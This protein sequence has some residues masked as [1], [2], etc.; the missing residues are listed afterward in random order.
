[1]SIAETLTALLGKTHGTRGAKGRKANDHKRAAFDEKE[2]AA[3]AQ[4]LKTVM[5]TD[6]LTLVGSVQMI[7]LGRLRSHFGGRWDTVSDKVHALVRSVIEKRTLGHDVHARLGEDT[8]VVV[9]SRMQPEAARMKGALM[10]EEIARKIFGDSPPADLIQVGVASLSPDDEPEEVP[11]PA[12][13]AQA[14]LRIAAGSQESVIDVPVPPAA[15]ASVAGG[16]P[17]LRPN[18]TNDASGAGTFNSADPNWSRSGTSDSKA[19][20]SWC[21]AGKDES[22]PANEWQRVGRE[23]PEFMHEWRRIGR[24][25][26]E[27]EH[28]WRP[29]ANGELGIPQ[30]LR[31]VYQPAWLVNRQVIAAHTF[32]PARVA[33]DGIVVAGGAAMPYRL[34]TAENYSLDLLGLMKVMRNLEQMAKTRAQACVIFPL[35]LQTLDL[36]RQRK[37][38]TDYATSIPDDMRAKLL[39]E[40]MGI[41]DTTPMSTTANAVSTLKPLCRNVLVRVRLETRSMSDF[42][43]LGVHAVGIDLGNLGWPEKDLFPMLNEFNLRAQKSRLCTFVHGIS[44]RSLLSGSVAAGFRY[45]DGCA[46]ATPVDFPMPNRRWTP[47]DVYSTL[48]GDSASL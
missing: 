15:P 10:A 2:I 27:F 9:F 21:R 44:T 3:F 8:Y 11:R 48:V 31:F 7:G 42:L 12:V 40:I 35:H 14:A 25:E 17:A 32:L 43:T 22:D 1:M 28:Q 4:R 39:F 29:I 45:L 47:M 36:P 38:F 46:I 20:A 37:M 18:G 23:E 34:P 24:D 26:P 5:N 16:A 19:A 13:P 33:E 30:D 41:S 6:Q